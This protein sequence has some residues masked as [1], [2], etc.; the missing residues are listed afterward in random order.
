MNY[1]QKY[2]KYKSKY[3][4][5]LNETNKCAKFLIN[6]SVLFVE[7]I[8]VNIEFKNCNLK[9]NKIIE[10]IIKYAK[11][12]NLKHIELEDNSY[13]QYPDKYFDAIDAEYYWSL[14]YIY[15]DPI[16]PSIYSQF[17]FKNKIF[18]KELEEK[19]NEFK[20]NNEKLFD[21]DIVK[22]LELNKNSFYGKRFEREYLLF[23]NYMYNVLL[24][25]LNQN[26]DFNLIEYK[27]LNLK[28][29]FHYPYSHFKLNYMILEI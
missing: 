6:D 13:L 28:K 9:F 25:I 14:I 8:L 20:I 22:E 23:D 15:R 7:D 18:L 10:N 26:K 24:E 5:L 2:L 16:K 4:Y 19:V 1:Y 27:N 29:T 12:N 21:Y 3:L 17:G 11:K